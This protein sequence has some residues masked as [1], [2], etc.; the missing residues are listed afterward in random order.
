[1]EKQQKSSRGTLNQHYE[2][3]KANVLREDAPHR[4][5]AANTTKCFISHFVIALK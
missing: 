3:T 1:M 2:S 5:G 4:Q